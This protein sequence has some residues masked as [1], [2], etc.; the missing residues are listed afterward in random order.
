MLYRVRAFVGLKFLKKVD[1]P[2]GI[3]RVV[4]AQ[5][6]QLACAVLAVEHVPLAPMNKINYIQSGEPPFRCFPQRRPLLCRLSCSDTK[7]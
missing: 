4:V 5:S 3:F 1:D 6:L 2:L 7:P